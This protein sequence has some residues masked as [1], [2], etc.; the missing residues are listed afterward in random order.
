MAFH[1]PFKLQV[2]QKPSRRPIQIEGNGQAKCKL[3]VNYLFE[4]VNKNTAGKERWFAHQ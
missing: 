3:G 2:L 4:K 1:T